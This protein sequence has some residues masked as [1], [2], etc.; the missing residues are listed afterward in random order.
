MSKT[1]IETKIEHILIG[2][3]GVD[4]GTVIVGDP[5]NLKEF[6]NDDFT[7]QPDPDQEQFDFSYNGA[8]QA[9]MVGGDVIGEFPHIPGAGMA[10]A[11][12]TAHGDGIYPVFHVVKDGKLV[13]L[14]VD[15]TP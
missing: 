10:V 1:E 5:G 4:S 3:I 11:T 15:F 8:A 13:G 7:S 6:V 9:A 2:H 14:F 12:G